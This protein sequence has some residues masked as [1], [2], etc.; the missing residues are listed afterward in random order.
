MSI[1]P[2]Q[3]SLT[4]E[5]RQLLARLS[6]QSGKPWDTVLDEALSSFGQIASVKPQDGESVYDAM[7]RLGLLG[8]ISD[9]PS[10]LSTNP[11]YMEGLWRT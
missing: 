9:G 11:E 7:L 10:D 4:A 5:Q 6:Q 3:I 1:S 2:D 8:S